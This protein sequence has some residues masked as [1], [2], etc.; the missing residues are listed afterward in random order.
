MVAINGVDVVALNTTFVSRVTK[1][2]RTVGRADS[3]LDGWSVGG[4]D[5]RLVEQVGLPDKL[6]PL[7]EP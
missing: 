6:F 7:V 4:T 5:E 1:T 3:R 2:E